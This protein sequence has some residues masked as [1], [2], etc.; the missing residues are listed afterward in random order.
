MIETET[1]G[2]FVIEYE[3]EV[4]NRWIAELRGWPGAVAYGSTRADARARLMRVAL[5]AC[6]RD[7]EESQSES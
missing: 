5:F 6:L 3:Q 4:D 1:E 2:D 7:I